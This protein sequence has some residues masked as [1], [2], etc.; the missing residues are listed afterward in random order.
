MRTALRKL[1]VRAPERWWRDSQRRAR[2]I[3]SL[4][5]RGFEADAAISAVTEM[6][7]SR[8]NTADALDDQ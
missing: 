8:E 3:S 2:M 1:E 5:A 6:A 4:I 7:A